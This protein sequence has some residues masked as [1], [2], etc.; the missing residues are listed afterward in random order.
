MS[1]RI[2]R[3][4]ELALFAAGLAGVF[5]PLAPGPAARRRK[6]ELTALLELDDHLLADIGLDRGAIARATRYGGPLARMGW[7]G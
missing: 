2:H 7:P 1:G 4:A 6:A 3:G 5:A